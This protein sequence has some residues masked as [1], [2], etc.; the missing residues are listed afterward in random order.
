MTKQDK[1][2]VPALFASIAHVRDGFPFGHLS[3][4]QDLDLIRSQ[5]ENLSLRTP[6]AWECRDPREGQI[7]ITNDAHRLGIQLAGQFA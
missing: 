5:Q 3:D 6:S 2:F 4:K 1:R 7:R